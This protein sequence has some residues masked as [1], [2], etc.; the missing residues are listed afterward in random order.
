MPPN[1]E[2]PAARMGARAGPLN[3]SSSA[4]DGS[5]SSPPNP[6][7]QAISHVA[8]RRRLV[9]HLHRLGPAPLAH[10]ISDIE[11]GAGIDA[12]LERYGRLPAEFVLAFGG[13]RFPEPMFAIRRGRR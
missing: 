13:D 9:T 4:P 3:A 8:R 7:P 5:Q 10:F 11:R 1:N 12:T 2:N 6:A